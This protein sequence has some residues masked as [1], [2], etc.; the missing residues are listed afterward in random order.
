MESQGKRKISNDDESMKKKARTKSSTSNTS[1]LSYRGK[2]LRTR[3]SE[4]KTIYLLGSGE[5]QS[6]GVVVINQALHLAVKTEQNLIILSKSKIMGCLYEKNL[7]VPECA[8]ALVLLFEDNNQV[9]RI[10]ICID[11]EQCE[12]LFNQA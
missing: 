5:I 2:P 10:R 11:R 7:K 6:M 8:E 3:T 12:R 4:S 1:I 9:E